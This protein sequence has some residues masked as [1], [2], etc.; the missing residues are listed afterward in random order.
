MMQA[1]TEF[2]SCFPQYKDTL[3]STALVQG[4]HDE[5]T[6]LLTKEL[7]YSHYYNPNKKLSMFRGSSMDRIDN[8]QPALLMCRQAD[9][10]PPSYS[11]TITIGHTLHHFQDMAV[12]AHV[13]PVSHSFWD[14][15][16]N[17]G[18]GGDIS[19]GWSCGDMAAAS[20]DELETIL[21]G[22]AVQTLSAVGGWQVQA[23]GKMTHTLHGSDFWVPSNDDGFGS[24]G[25]AGNQ[26]G[27]TQFSYAG[28]TVAIDDQEYAAFKQQQ[29]KLAVQASLRGLAWILRPAAQQ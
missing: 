11:D 17:Y 16:E 9:P 6:D 23:T 8:L 20:N 13:V 29:M 22:T 25:A 12:P 4:D 10:T 27:T 24:Y 14:G 28:D 7:F 1:Y 26:F 2:V 5:D 3:D 18:F 19:S 21:Q 15:F